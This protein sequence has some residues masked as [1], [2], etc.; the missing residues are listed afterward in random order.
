MIKLLDLLEEIFK[1]E[2][3][4]KD[5]K[6]SYILKGAILK[7]Y[8]NKILKCEE[9]QCVS[10]IHVIEDTDLMLRDHSTTFELQRGTMLKNKCF[11]Q[12]IVYVPKHSST[13]GN[14]KVILRG[15]V[16]FLSLSIINPKTRT[17]P[18]S[19]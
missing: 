8:R 11:L 3:F 4:N 16:D 6:E 17:S 15:K 1:L 10:G 9:F 5:G 19:A 7:L 2:H 13:D 14:R 12:Y 18:G